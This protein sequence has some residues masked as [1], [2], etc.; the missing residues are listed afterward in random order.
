MYNVDGTA[1]KQSEDPSLEVL[2]LMLFA[3]GLTKVAAILVPMV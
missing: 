2:A 3:I 1:Y